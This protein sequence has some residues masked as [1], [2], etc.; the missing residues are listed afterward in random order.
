VKMY[1]GKD[2]AGPN[3]QDIEGKTVPLKVFE[4]RVQGERNYLKQRHWLSI[5]GSAGESRGRVKQK[6]QDFL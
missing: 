4:G 3:G 2:P 5:P 6:S 1:P